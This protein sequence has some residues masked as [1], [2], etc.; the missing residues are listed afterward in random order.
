MSDLTELKRFLL[1][2]C[3][4]AGF[5]TAPA[6]GAGSDIYEVRNVRVDVSAETASKAREKAL[7]DGE[8]AAFERLM[9]RL[10]M[11][12]DRERLPN[13]DKGEIRSYVR[14]FAVSNEKTS[15]G[16]YLANLSVRF[17][18]ESVRKLLNDFNL[19]FAETLSKPVLVLP[20]FQSGGSMALWDDPN[21][22][23][24][25]WADLRARSGLVPLIQ[26]MGDLGDVGA[27]NP[28]QAI[29][30]D[31]PR[32]KV[33]AERYQAQDVVVVYGLQRLDPASGR[34]SLEVY[35]TRYGKD[36]D[37]E[38]DT[39]P[40]NQEE[41]ESASDLLTRAVT[42]ISDAIDDD[43]KR[44]NILDLSHPNVAAIAVP[45]TGLKDWIAVQAR[46]KDVPLIRRAEM[47]LLSLDEIRINL[48][49]VGNT[50]QLRNA[51]AQ[52]ELT[53]VNEDGEWVLYLADV[54][55]AGKT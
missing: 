28:V 12:A 44:R 49:Y 39:Y 25:A 22:W 2:V 48:H 50:T 55:P 14:D 9:R 43:W 1:V 38:T 54:R 7:A 26:P 37:P 51:L 41:G 23:R 17:K 42:R 35:V 45:V 52:A 5:G 20:V 47:V 40:F 53:L 11:A 33:V 36:P 18:R 21:P 34:Q 19:P 32:L 24:G 15:A 3:V 6:V 29:Q 30:G 27:I 13:L 16:R 8:R 31:R 10:T 4:F 46:L